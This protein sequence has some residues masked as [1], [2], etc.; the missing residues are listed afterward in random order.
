ML[1]FC[2]PGDEYTTPWING[3]FSRCFLETVGSMA[4]AGTLILLGLTVIV[5]GPKSKE[6]K[7][8]KSARQR[9]SRLFISKLLI[10]EGIICGLL[11][12][13]YLVD[14][15][16][17]GTLRIAGE[18][19]YGYTIV[20]DALGL[21]SWVFAILLLYRER[22]LILKGKT[23]GFPL[24]LFW[25]LNVVWFSLQIVSINNTKWW[26]DLST[27]ADISDLVLYV[28]RT[29]L[30]SVIVVLGIFRPV[31][32]PPKQ[33]HYTLLVNVEPGDQT[34]KEEGD[35]IDTEEKNKESRERKEG[36][37]IRK[38]TSSAFSDFWMK[39]KLLFPYVWP[40]GMYT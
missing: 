35:D 31:C 25:I 6:K 26:W 19:I 32:C 10:V 12:L 3:G 30:L 7:T 13:T 21:W 24:A 33:R 17:K 38:R 23:H 36:S 20:Q 1:P 15:V 40:K 8:S 34:D 22:V 5:L 29:V 37:F 28:V 39:T 9:S 11:S 14:I 27:R 16:V 4:C 2:E 18:E